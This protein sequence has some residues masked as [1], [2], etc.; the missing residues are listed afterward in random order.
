MPSVK[1]TLHIHCTRGGP[2][3]NSLLTLH[4]DSVL[5][6]FNKQVVQ[7]SIQ[8]QALAPDAD[9]LCGCLCFRLPLPLSDSA[10]ALVALL[11]HNICGNGLL[12][13]TV[14]HC[15]TDRN[16]FPESL[17]KLP[18]RDQICCTVFFPAPVDFAGRGLIMLNCG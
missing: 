15:M 11:Q 1:L 9:T 6:Y 3:T 10:L 7:L 12:T 17:A 8:P 5:L 16:A 14:A 18:Y 2:N 4:S 13:L